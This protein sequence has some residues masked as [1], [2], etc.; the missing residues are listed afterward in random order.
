MI[1]ALIVLFYISRI[2]ISFF[3]CVLITLWLIAAE[4]QTNG[5]NLLFYIW[6]YFVLLAV[7]DAIQSKVIKKNDY[8]SP[9]EEKKQ[10]DF[11]HWLAEYKQHVN[12][13]TNKDSE[14]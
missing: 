9:E 14:S 6:L 3:L 13:C 4:G 10:N 12:D 8:F 5:S 7:L 1:L 11:D 2:T